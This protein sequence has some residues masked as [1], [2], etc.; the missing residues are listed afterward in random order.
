MAKND[1]IIEKLNQFMKAQNKA[2]A[3]G[4]SEFVCPLCG[5]AALWGRST[6]NNHLHC[7]CRKCGFKM[8]E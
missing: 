6:Y 2:E 7:G 5:G 4:E 3:K 1:E 8:M